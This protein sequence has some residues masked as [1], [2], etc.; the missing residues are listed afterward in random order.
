MVTLMVPP[1]DNFVGCSDGSP[2]W[3]VAT[4]AGEHARPDGDHGGDVRDLD[5]AGL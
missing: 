4:Q 3:R 5:P 1:D 2:I